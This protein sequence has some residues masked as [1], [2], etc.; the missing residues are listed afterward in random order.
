MRA[1]RS[2][3]CRN[4]KHILS[5]YSQLIQINRHTTDG[6]TALTQSCLDGN[7]EVV[8]VLLAHGANPELTNRDGFSPFHVACFVGRMDLI[9]YF[10]TASSGR[11]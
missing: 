4:L 11:R 7:L 1:V 6:Q 9:K 3:D 8:K 5:R 2:G 10:L